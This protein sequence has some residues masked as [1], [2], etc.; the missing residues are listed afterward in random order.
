M[1]KLALSALVILFFQWAHAQSFF[2]EDLE[3]GKTGR[4]KITAPYL[5]YFGKSGDN[6][7]AIGAKGSKVMVTEYKGNLDRI[8]EFELKLKYDGN[9]ID[10][11]NIFEFQ[12][13]LMCLTSYYNQ[14]RE[15]RYYFIQKY[16]GHG[17]LST[18]VPVCASEWNKTMKTTLSYDR[19][20]ESMSKERSIKILVSEDKNSFGILIP[21]TN[22]NEVTNPNE[23][24]VFVFNEG[25]AMKSQK[26]TAPKKGISISEFV[27]TN[28]GDL[29]AVG[30]EN[31]KNINDAFFPS[32]QR[33]NLFT[34]QFLGNK[35]YGIFYDT[36]SGESKWTELDVLNKDVIS[37]RVKYLNGNFIV[38]G[39]YSEFSP[40][41]SKDAPKGYFYFKMDD[42]AT[43]LAQKWKDFN[44]FMD[45]IEEKKD[46]LTFEKEPKKNDRNLRNQNKD[47]IIRDVFLKTN[48]EVVILA[49]EFDWWETQEA[50]VDG[51]SVTIYHFEYGDILAVSCDSDGNSKWMQRIFKR[52]YSI[53]DYGFYSSYS[54]VEN[55][56]SLHF[57]M[58]DRLLYT[59]YETYE[60]ESFLDRS[61][62][63][64][65]VVLGGATISNNGQLDRYVVFDS[66]KYSSNKLVPRCA[67]SG[68]NELILFGRKTINTARVENGI[69]S[70]ELHQK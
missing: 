16:L 69:S 41:L 5:W 52:Q 58:N 20:V 48:G 28:N 19:Y 66:E 33:S 7:V 13:V 51:S 4:L 37:Y 45:P 61:K 11:E 30:V 9:R 18:P 26:I 22:T 46:E 62:A 6:Y 10:L 38:C 39:F 24:D 57:L 56:N 35:Y 55:E 43:I 64:E 40:L 50:A 63:K 29:L 31:V 3:E 53:D 27:M 32:A 23:W 47:L 25:L 15:L 59:D 68:T 2:G 49:E 67:I 21:R 1:M 8:D 12:G 17:K 65:I 42:S 34:P 36:K 60:N 14:S 44:S 54:V 70:L